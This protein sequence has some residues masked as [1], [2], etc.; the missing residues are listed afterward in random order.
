M[1]FTEGNGS[2]RVTER[3]ILL[4]HHP[5]PLE[6]HG[7]YYLLSRFSLS[8]LR[9]VR[10]AWKK[11]L[12]ATKWLSLTDLHSEEHCLSH[13]LLCHQLQ[14]EERPWIVDPLGIIVNKLTF[15]WLSG[16]KGTIPKRKS[17]SSFFQN[18]I[19]QAFQSSSSTRAFR[20]AGKIRFVR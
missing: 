5:Q 11:N 16:I 12:N 17:N 20:K 13:L 1:I 6:L 2:F 18:P 14:Y 4:G 19:G 8:V 9:Q 3:D 7:L 10:A 15:N